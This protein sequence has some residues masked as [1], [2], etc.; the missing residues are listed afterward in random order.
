[1]RIVK[2]IVV[3]IAIIPYSVCVSVALPF[4]GAHTAWKHNV[5]FGKVLK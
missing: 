3:F 5:W 1:M 2:T 4:I